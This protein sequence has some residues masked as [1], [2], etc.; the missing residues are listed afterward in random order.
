[1]ESHLLALSLSCNDFEIRLIPLLHDI[2]KP[3][4]YQDKEIRHFVGHATVSSTSRNILERL[5]YNDDSLMKFA[6]YRY[7][8]HYHL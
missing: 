5:K 2:G 3:H 7:T 8:T 6:I 1:M 4:C